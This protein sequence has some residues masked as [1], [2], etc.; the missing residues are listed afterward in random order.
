MFDMEEEKIIQIM[1][2]PQGGYVKHKDEKGVFYTKIV[3]IALTN[4][5]VAFLNTDDFGDIGLL[6]GG[7]EVVFLENPPKD[8]YKE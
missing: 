6:S 1:P 7:E 3:G 2:A 4:Y 8:E 5:G